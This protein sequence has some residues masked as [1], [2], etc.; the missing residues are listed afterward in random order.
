MLAWY[1]LDKIAS[2]FHTKEVKMK[3]LSRKLPKLPKDVG[4]EV[5]IMIGIQYLKYHHNEI[6]TLET[7]LT[8]YRSA[9]KNPE[10]DL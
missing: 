9:F 1:S 10:N 3:R 5:D 6:A 4:G 2:D 7:V 8:L